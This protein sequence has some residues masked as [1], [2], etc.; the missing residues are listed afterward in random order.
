[1][2]AVHALL[3]HLEAMGFDSAP[4][5]VGSV[6]QEWVAWAYLEGDIQQPDPWSDEGITQLGAMIREFHE[7]A[8]SL[9]PPDDAVWQRWWIHDIRPDTGIGHGELAPWNILTVDGCP[10]A[11]I[12]W[13]FAG[14]MFL[15]GYDLDHDRRVGFVDLMIEIAVHSC[16]HEAQI[17]GAGRETHE[18]GVAAWAMRWRA[19]SAAWMLRHRT[20][21][22]QSIS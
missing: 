2:A 4:R 7:A 17:S 22:T 18:V 12:D 10:S 9:V 15:Y 8:S 3:H 1:M 20:L 21:L 5:P 14:P 16:A 13:E 11:I 6:D 19:E